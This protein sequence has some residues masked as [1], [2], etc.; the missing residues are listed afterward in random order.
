MQQTF[1]HLHSIAAAATLVALLAVAPLHSARAFELKPDLPHVAVSY[2]GIAAAGYDVVAFFMQG[3]PIRGKAHIYALY[4]GATYRFSSEANRDMFLTHPAQFTP[5]F[6]GYGAYGIRVGVKLKPR[7]ALSWQIS[8]DGLLLFRDED[9]KAMWNDNANGNLRI[10]NIVW[11]KVHDL[12]GL[13]L[14]A[15][16]SF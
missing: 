6:G 12:P 16:A 2:D 10:A 3:A 7:A 11:S 1:K 15:P 4:D 8:S 9:A 14:A 5:L 13:M